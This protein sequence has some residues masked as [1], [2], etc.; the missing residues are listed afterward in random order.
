MPSV[1]PDGKWIALAGQKNAGQR[2]DQTKNSIWLLSDEGTIRALESTH[3]QGRTPAW[4]P[5]GEW[6]TFE[7]NRGSAD[8]S[9]YAVFIIRRDG[10]GIRQLTPHYINA[11]HPIWSRDGRYVTFSA[12]HTSG[13]T[14]TGIAILEVPKCRWLLSPTT[15]ESRG[16]MAESSL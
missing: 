15:C 3:A 9:L 13:S 4:S 11:N 2:Y 1:S 8:P 10:T 6:L 7:S 5:D 12:R 16:Q 14:R